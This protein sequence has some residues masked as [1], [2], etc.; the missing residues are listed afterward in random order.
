MRLKSL[1]KN[2]I[3]DPI[4]G[5]VY[6]G[7]IRSENVEKAVAILVKN[8]FNVTYVNKQENEFNVKVEDDTF[9]RSFNAGEKKTTHGWIPNSK[10][11]TLY[12][13]IT[14]LGYIPTRLEDSSGESGKYSSGKLKRLILVEHEPFIIITFNRKFDEE[15]PRTELPKIL[16]HVTSE[17]NYKKIK[18]IGFKPTSKSK[19]KYH[20]ERVYFSI[21]YD[22]IEILM[23][24]PMFDGANFLLEIDTSKIP[25][26]VKFFRDPDFFEH[27]I[28]TFDNIPKEAITKVSAV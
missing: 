10:L 22:G 27:G 2:I 16:Y 18:S 25:S 20:P 21:D 5:K 17:Q 14:N 7:L 19:L 1:L 9:K 6:E 8:G 12:S 23:G 26:D 24:H 28:Y 11:S 3:H 15:I 13:L 4:S